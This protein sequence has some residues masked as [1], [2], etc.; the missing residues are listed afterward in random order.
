MVTRAAFPEP[1]TQ[2]VQYGSG[3][4]SLAVYAPGSRGYANVYQLLPLERTSDLLGDIGKQWL[5]EGR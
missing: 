1:V 4:A 5:S 2:P 3:I